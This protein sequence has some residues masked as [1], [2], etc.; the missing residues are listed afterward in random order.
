MARRCSLSRY[1]GEG[2]R[3]E[4]GREGARPA[5]GIAPP[6]SA[7]PFTKGGGYPY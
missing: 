4:R 1:A 2:G 6:P 7:A 3:A 5:I